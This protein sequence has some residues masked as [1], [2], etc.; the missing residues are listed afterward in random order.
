[1]SVTTPKYRL[2]DLIHDPGVKHAPELSRQLFDRDADPFEQTDLIESPDG[3]LPPDVQQALEGYLAE[4]TP[5]WGVPPSEEKLEEME[6][7]QLRA[8]GYVIQ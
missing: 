5:P 6:L 7:N 2:I 4:S 1:V 8:L 3:D